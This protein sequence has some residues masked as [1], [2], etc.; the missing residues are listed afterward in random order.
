MEKAGIIIR[1]ASKWG[2][3]ILFLPKKKGSEELRVVNNFIPLNMYIRKPA[4]PTYLIEEVTNILNQADLGYYI[5]ADMLSS[6]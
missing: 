3:A 1:G 2:A 4:Y 5:N 6:Y